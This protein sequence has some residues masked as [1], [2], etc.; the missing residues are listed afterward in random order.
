MK[1]IN[2]AELFLRCYAQKEAN[3]DWFAICIDLNVSATGS[4]LN[5]VMEDVHNQIADYVHEAFTDDKEH[6]QRLLTRKAPLY[7]LAQYHWI[8]LVLG[9]RNLCSLAKNQLNKKIFNEQLPLIPA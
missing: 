3:D 9:F 4:T 6:I 5:D 7:F 8:S 2:P 1:K